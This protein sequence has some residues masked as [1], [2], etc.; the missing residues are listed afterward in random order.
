MQNL[1]VPRRAL[2]IPVRPARV[3]RPRTVL[4]VDPHADTRAVYG[5]FLRRHGF[6]VLTASDGA[7]G[8]RLALEHRPDVVVTE[9]RLPGIDGWTMLERIKS[10]PDLAFTPLLAVTAAVAE[11]SRAEALASGFA[12]IIAKPCIPERV[13]AEVRRVT[14]EIR[15]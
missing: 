7:E 2:R 11:V 1:M 8:A 10:H 4:L 6:H 12:E 9:L 14:A 5:A 3:E 13:L 15:G